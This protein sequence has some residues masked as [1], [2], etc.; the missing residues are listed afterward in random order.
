MLHDS[1]TP[2]WTAARLWG[3]GLCLFVSAL[4]TASELDVPLGAVMVAEI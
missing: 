2:L 1:H 3:V 4:P